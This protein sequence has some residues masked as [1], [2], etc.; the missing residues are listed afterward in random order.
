MIRQLIL[1]LIVSVRYFIVCSCARIYEEPE[2]HYSS[3]YQEESINQIWIYHH[4][5]DGKQCDTEKARPPDTV[6]ILLD[7]GIAVYDFY[8]ESYAFCKACR[9]PDYAVG[10]Y[11][12]I[13]E[14]D[15]SLARQ[16]GFIP[17]KGIVCPILSA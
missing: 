16:L 13:A 2:V 5:S 10:H 11:V 3:L 9:C 15:T 8:S 1:L 4:F 7:F 6:R 17:N 14:A 12:L